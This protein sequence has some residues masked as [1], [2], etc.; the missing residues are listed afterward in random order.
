M[1]G[2]HAK[3]SSKMT[4][5]EIQALYDVAENVKGDLNLNDIVIIGQLN[6]LLLM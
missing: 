6:H 1:I 4:F 3:A 5:D 2:I